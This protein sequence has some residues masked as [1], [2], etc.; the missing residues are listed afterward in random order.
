MKKDYKKPNIFSEKT[1]GLLP[2]VGAGL[3][4]AGGYVVGRGVKQAFEVRVNDVMHNSLNKVVKS[5]E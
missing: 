2:V 4:L 3:A 5:K 1:A